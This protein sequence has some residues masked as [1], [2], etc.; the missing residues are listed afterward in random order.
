MKDARIGPISADL[1]EAEEQRMNARDIVTAL[2]RQEEASLA[3]WNA[4]DGEAFF[5]RIGES[6]SPAETVRHLAKSTRPV[7]K[8]LR[9]PRIV[10][11]CMFGKPERPSM[12][13]D[14]IVTRY[15]ALLA[16]GGQAGRFAPS[17]RGSDREVIM[18]SFVEANRDLRTGIARWPESKLDAV[19]LPHPLLGKLT[20][21]EM[22]L[23]T[24]YHHRHHIEV[25]KRRMQEQAQKGGA[26]AG[27]G[28]EA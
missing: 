5:A 22:L 19:Q 4:F 20:V 13:Y 8:A 1:R 18:N 15:R 6:W 26:M 14:E 10:L 23:F 24:L 3:W 27:G 12:T 2:E 17:S 9:M 7:A 21:R 11:R 25:V 28:P 16:E